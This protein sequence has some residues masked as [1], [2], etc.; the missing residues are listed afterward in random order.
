VERYEDDQEEAL[1]EDYVSPVSLTPDDIADQEFK[2]AMRGYAR[3]EVREFLRFTAAELEERDAQIAEL[4]R[5]A[6]EREAPHADREYL[7]NT[8]GQE[9]GRAL[10]DAESAA[11]NMRTSATDQGDRIITDARVEADRMRSEARSEAE[12]TLHSARRQAD[13]IVAQA[14]ADVAGARAKLEDLRRNLAGAQESLSDLAGN[15]DAAAGELNGQAP[16]STPLAS[17]KAHPGP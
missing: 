6:L 1:I 9:I 4:E 15:V 11:A 10:I 2:L 5:R 7:L 3:E 16:P 8:L 12:D 14:N 17:V 13:E